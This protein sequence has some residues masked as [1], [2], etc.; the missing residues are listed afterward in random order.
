MLLTGIMGRIPNSQH[1]SLQAKIKA[2][3]ITILT[4]SF[5]FPNNYSQK[6]V[7]WRDMPSP[8]RHGSPLKTKKIVIKKKKKKEIFGRPSESKALLRQVLA[9]V[10]QNRRGSPFPLSP[11]SHPRRKIEP[12]LVSL[13]L[14]DPPV[15]PLFQLRRVPG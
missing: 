14:P 13:L 4:L 10:N 1:A 6:R 3:A 2:P 11:V 15:I 12:L 7:L 9:G 5:E 8:N